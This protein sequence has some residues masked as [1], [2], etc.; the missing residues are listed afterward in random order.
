MSIRNIALWGVLNMVAGGAVFVLA[1]NVDGVRKELRK[2]EREIAKEQE[3]IR[4]LDAE[5]AW[6]T[7]PERLQ[8]LVQNLTDLH[9]IT[10]KQLANV[11]KVSDLGIAEGP[12]GPTCTAL[13]P[14]PRKPTLDSRGFMLAT[15]RQGGNDI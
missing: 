11:D 3:T 10:P 4:V 6:L 15:M 1:H 9:P 14:P 13:K 2:A 8:D 12:R 5:W 7:R